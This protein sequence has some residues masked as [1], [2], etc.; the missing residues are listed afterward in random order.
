MGLP[1]SL[2]CMGTGTHSLKRG[3]KKSSGGVGSGSPTPGDSTA[4]STLFDLLKKPYYYRGNRKIGGLLALVT[5]SLFTLDSHFRN[6]PFFWTIMMTISLF[7]EVH[8]PSRWSDISLPL[9]WKLA[10]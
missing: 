6:V 3:P 4:S 1:A 10:A 2:P 5:L 7:R 8:R 9:L